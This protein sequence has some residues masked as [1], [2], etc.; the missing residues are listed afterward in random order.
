MTDIRLAVTAADIA[1]AQGL[2]REYAGTLDVD[3]GYQGFEREVAALPGDYAPPRGA[4]LLAGPA[5]APIGCVALRPLDW[6]HSAE[7]KRLYV[8]PAGRGQGLGVRLAEAALA[9]A[10]T[11][12]YERICL[13]T[14]PS[15]A[16]AQRLYEA[17]GFRDVPP[18][19]F[20]PVAGT[21][22][23]ER[24]LGRAR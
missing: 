16:T 12:G 2:F 14:L 19:R 13:D 22:Y 6:P 24:S 21:R 18:Y 1:A 3:L 23:M 10:E 7:L 20:S 15:M 5:D 9:L 11:I 8:A 17:L 4:L